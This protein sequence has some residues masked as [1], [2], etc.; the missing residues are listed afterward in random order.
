MGRFS[1]KYSNIKFSENPSCVSWAMDNFANV[2]KNET[3]LRGVY[4]GN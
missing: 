1:K 2:T 4:A 3:V